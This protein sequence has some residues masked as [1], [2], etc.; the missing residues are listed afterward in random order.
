M[1][2]ECE[3]CKT[4]MSIFWYPIEIGE[5]KIWLCDNCMY[6]FVKWMKGELEE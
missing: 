6:K 2:C 4:S 3:K 1:I 5:R